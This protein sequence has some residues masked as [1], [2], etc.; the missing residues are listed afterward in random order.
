MAPQSADM[1]LYSGENDNM[2]A[3]WSVYIYLSFN[4]DGTME[5]WSTVV[6]GSEDEVDEGD[7]GWGED[8]EE[9]R[10]HI[11]GIRGAAALLEAVERCGRYVE[12]DYVHDIL[13]DNLEDF[14]RHDPAL[15]DAL[16]ALLAPESVLGRAGGP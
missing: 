13:S 7:E 14:Q 1:T 16:E 8:A 5:V 12:V 2:F 4:K 3:S 10:E 11:T 9:V 15:H 6:G